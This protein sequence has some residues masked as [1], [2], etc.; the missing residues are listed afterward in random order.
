MCGRR[1][2]RWPWPGWGRW[3]RWSRRWTHSR[4]EAAGH[5]AVGEAGPGGLGAGVGFTPMIRTGTPMGRP[6]RPPVSTPMAIFRLSVPLPVAGEVRVSVVTADRRCRSWPPGRLPEVVRSVT[7]SE[8]VMP[9]G[10]RG[11]RA[12]PCRP[13]VSGHVRR[14]QVRPE[15]GQLTPVGDLRGSPWRTTAGRPC[16]W[17]RRRCRCWRCW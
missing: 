17:A 7:V 11:R 5:A 9:G 13:L 8:P 15:V 14:S 1:C 2:H 12:W 3:R 10:E 6:S 4:S 16:C